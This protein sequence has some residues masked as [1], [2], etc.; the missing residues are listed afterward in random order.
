VWGR[1]GGILERMCG[2][3]LVELWRGCVGQSWWNC[4][5]V[6]W[7]IVGGN[8]KTMCGESWWK[9]EDGLWARVGGIVEM[10]CGAGFVES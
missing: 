9:F 5:D 6:I 3:E 1:V 10:R 4:G 7:S 2:A 8:V